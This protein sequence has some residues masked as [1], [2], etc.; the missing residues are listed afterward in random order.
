MEFEFVKTKLL[1]TWAKGQQYQ[2]H[3]PE[4]D[5]IAKIILASISTQATESDFEAS[6]L[7]HSATYKDEIPDY[8][9]IDF[10]RP[11]AYDKEKFNKMNKTSIIKRI[12][13]LSGL[14]VSISNKEEML[15]KIK[16]GNL[17]SKNFKRDYLL[18]VTV[19]LSRDDLMTIYA[20]AEE[21][22]K[23]E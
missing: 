20:P 5:S 4:E 6:I 14:K 19:H 21:V 8:I 9:K 2:S 16:N 23:T 10:P 12:K 11:I 15:S 17:P 13:S 22:Q 1:N 18:R 3:T 7:E